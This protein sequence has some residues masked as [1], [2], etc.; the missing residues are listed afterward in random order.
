M[1]VEGGGAVERPWWHSC[2]SLR[3]AAEGGAAPRALGPV[4]VLRA[5]AHKGPFHS[6]WEEQGGR[7]A[8]T[9]EQLCVCLPPRS[10][11]HPKDTASWGL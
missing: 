5:G 9:K 1:G 7:T 10:P 6:L 2:A 3:A 8:W 11:A 4:P